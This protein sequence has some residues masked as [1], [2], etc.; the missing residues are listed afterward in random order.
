[1]GKITRLFTLFVL[2]K[3]YSGQAKKVVSLMYVEYTIETST[4]RKFIADIGY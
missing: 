4:A 2:Y 1:M 3:A